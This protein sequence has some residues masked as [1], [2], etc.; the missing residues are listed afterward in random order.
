MTVPDVVLIGGPPGAGKTTLGRA[1]A[2][3]IGHAHLTVDDL[4]VAAK[5][6]TTPDTHPAFHLM[7]DGHIAYFTNGPPEKL[8]A[9]S[10]AQEAVTWPIVERLT[11]S[12]LRS[13]SPMVIDWWLL[14]PRT[15]AERFGA[16]VA[17]LW[18]HIEPNALRERE[19]SNSSFFE[20]SSDPDRM[21]SNFMHRSLWRNDLVAAE[22][23]HTGLPLLRLTGAEA[24][25]DLVDRAMAT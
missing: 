7:P 25:D 18:L 20:G 17:S 11:A 1:L 21:L 24:V 15:V 14:S 10:M 12:H 22:A 5:V 2:A 16:D 9:D 8:V 6:L 4:L 19:R 3:R 13:G 23:E